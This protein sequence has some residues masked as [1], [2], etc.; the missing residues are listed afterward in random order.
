MERM[1]ALKL[2]EKTR[3]IA[4]RTF[5][6]AFARSLVAIANHKEDTFRKISIEALRSLSMVNPALV[7]SV[8]GFIPLLD[9]IIEPINPPMADSI[10]LTILYLLND[11]HTRNLVS[12]SI[13]LRVLISPFTDLDS[14]S[15]DLAEKWKASRSAIVLSM[16]TWVGLI[17]LT[18]DHMGWATLVRMLRDPKVP[19]PTQEIILDMITE[20][21]EPIT[22]KV[23]KVNRTY[24]HQQQVWSTAEE[25]TLTAI[26][27]VPSDSALLAASV[28]SSIQSPSTHSIYGDTRSPS[29]PSSTIANKYSSAATQQVYAG[30]T[31]LSII[32]NT[33]TRSSSSVVSILSP[34]HQKRGSINKELKNTINSLFHLSGGSNKEAFTS[35]S[36]SSSSNNNNNNNV[37]N[38]NNNSSNNL[39]IPSIAST[40]SSSSSSN[41]VVKKHHHHHSAANSFMKQIFSNSSS[42]LKHHHNNNNNNNNNSSSSSRSNASSRS[43]LTNFEQDLINVSK[44]SSTTPPLPPPPFIKKSISLSKIESTTTNNNTDTA[45]ITAATGQGGGT[46]V[47][48]SSDTSLNSTIKPQVAVNNNTTTT[49]TTIESDF[50]IFKGKKFNYKDKDVVIDRSSS[51]SLDY[52]SSREDTPGKVESLRLAGYFNENEALIDPIFNLMDNYSALLCCAFLHV[53][54]IQSLYFLGKHISYG[55]DDGHD[56]DD[57]YD[58]NVHVVDD[59]DEDDDDDDDA[60]LY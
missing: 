23:K 33:T 34:T 40:S 10:L 57:D 14:S 9:A 31:N 25:Q 16:R 44:Q 39:T 53:N 41:E 38:S 35:S 32:T 4:P 50:K 28:N 46:M 45:S 11:P 48:S 7:A 52:T 26:H 2:I 55:D 24:R 18:S 47:Q 36:S 13:D 1:Q 15:R 29:T 37:S 30:Q 59:Y 22:Q 3:L 17:H 27:L 56:V 49:M 8:D 6:I 43:T 12:G 54:L 5:P 19:M 20:I 21:F 42:S 51:P 60:V 58:G